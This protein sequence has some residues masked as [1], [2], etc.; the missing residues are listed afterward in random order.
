MTVEHSCSDLM[1]LT[2]R[3]ICSHRSRG[4]L[5]HSSRETCKQGKVNYLL[6]FSGQKISLIAP[7]GYPNCMAN[8]ADSKGEGKS[9]PIRRMHRKTFS[10]SLREISLHSGIFSDRFPILTA[11]ILP[12]CRNFSK[13]PHPTRSFNRIVYKGQEGPKGNRGTLRPGFHANRRFFKKPL[14]PQESGR[15]L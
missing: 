5:R 9:R 1:L 11:G 13:R 15:R 4:R 14:S 2:C 10:L 12:P 8:Y 6:F 3:G 7:E